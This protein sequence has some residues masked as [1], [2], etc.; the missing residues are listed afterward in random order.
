MSLKA[1]K[2]PYKTWHI[3]CCV[4]TFINHLSRWLDYWLQK[5]KLLVETYLRGRPR[6]S[7]SAVRTRPSPFRSK[8]LHSRRKF[9]LDSLGDELPSAF[10]LDAVKEAMS[11]IMKNSLFEFGDLYF[12]HLLGTAMGTSA[13]YMWATI[14]FWV[15]ERNL[16]PAYSNYILFLRRFIGNMFRIWIPTST[17]ATIAWMSFQSNVNNFGVLT[18]EFS[19]L[20][21]AVDFLD[22]NLKIEGDTI[23]S[24]TYQK[25][26]KCTNTS[27]LP[28]PILLL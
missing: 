9:N 25:S 12:L 17:A 21:D 22:L 4:G 6:P 24:K 27:H 7:S 10:P 16:L 2:T 8:T 20:G 26:I 23:V 11:L 3:V 28:L 13:A 18:W 19:E 14:Y 5:L 1:H 15:Q